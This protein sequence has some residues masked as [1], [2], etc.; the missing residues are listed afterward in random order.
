MET[1]STKPY[2]PEHGRFTSSHVATINSRA[3]AG[4]VGAGGQTCRDGHVPGALHRRTEDLYLGGHGQ[5]DRA[6]RRPESLL[7]RGVVFLIVP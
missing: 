1:P 3:S 4:F 6:E 5:P 7:Q 2:C